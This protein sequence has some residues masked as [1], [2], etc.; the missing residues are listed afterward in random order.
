M[1]QKTLTRNAVRAGTS[2]AAK[3]AVEKIQARL[4]SAVPAII[5]APP[6]LLELHLHLLDGTTRTFVQD[7]PALVRQIIPQI[8]HGL[9]SHGL[10][11]QPALVLYGQD[12]VTVYP[13]SALAGLSLLMAPA[14][15][16]LLPL[17]PCP[18]I[19]ITQEDYQAEQHAPQG[20]VKEQP[21]L[22]RSEVEMSTGRRLWLAVPA[23][24]LIP[25]FQE[26]QM[27]HTLFSLPAFLCRRRG[28]GLSLW[29]RAQIV[30]CSF[31]PNLDV[32]GTA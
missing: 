26:R 25:G 7:D 18:C 21:F 27:L 23:L 19:E 14:D 5:Q 29:N 12:H 9:F 16:G 30:R 3:P 32:P 4:I 8:G 15:Q 31:Y 10:F 6:P 20:M 22:I 2:G 28:G 24:P 13:G 17:G 11:T 1:T